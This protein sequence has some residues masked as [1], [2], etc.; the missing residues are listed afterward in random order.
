MDVDEVVLY[1]ILEKKSTKMKNK[2]KYQESSI[3]F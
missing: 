3:D 2:F 1:E